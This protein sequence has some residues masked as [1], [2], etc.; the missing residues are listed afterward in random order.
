[1]DIPDH[2]IYFLFYLFLFI[3]LF[4]FFGRGAVTTIVPDRLE[5]GEL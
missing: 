1:M 2:F 5:V 3:Y 4:F